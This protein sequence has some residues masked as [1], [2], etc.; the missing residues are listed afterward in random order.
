MRKVEKIDGKLGNK[1][2]HTYPA[3]KDPW[4]EINK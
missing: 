1:V 2:F 3:V 4:H